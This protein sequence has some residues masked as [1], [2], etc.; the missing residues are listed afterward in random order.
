MRPIDAGPEPRAKVSLADVAR[1][2][3]T[4]HSAASRA[5][6][7]RVGVREPLRQAVLL[8]AAELGYVP[9]SS[10]RNLVMRRTGLI[11]LVF[12]EPSAVLGTTFFSELVASIVT[13]LDEADYRTVLLL[14]DDHRRKSL[15]DV[16]RPEAF[17]GALVIGQ[18]SEHGLAR[19][20]VQNGVPTVILGRPMDGLDVSFADI[21][22]V[23]AAVVAT[24]HLIAGG[25]RHPALLAGPQDTSWGVDRVEGFAKAVAEASGPGAEP[26]IEV[27][28]YAH[29]GGYEAMRRLLAAA[30][31]LD[32]LLVSSESFLPGALTA[33][34]EA[35]RRVPADVAV[36]SFDDGPR[37][38][39]ASPPITAVR[40]PLAE[41]GAEL[42]RLMLAAVEKPSMRINVNLSA[43][44]E[45]RASSR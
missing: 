2:A 34:A 12:A 29:D 17:D 45:V 1:R 7:G 11:A 41:L 19:R 27:C 10:A 25:S 9:N 16:V 33:L 30:P 32:G 23:D 31:D 20:F 36:V 13:T 8:A 3:G 4:S 6:N 35:G 18:R 26:A 22:N 42:A 37:L 14:P 38:A 15:G 39:F 43:S 40:Q 5:I 44:M 24:T 28:A 21:A